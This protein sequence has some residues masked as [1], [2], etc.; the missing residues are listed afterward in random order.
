M[1]NIDFTRVNNVSNKSLDNLFGGLVS[2]F[3]SSSVY[4]YTD[5]NAFLNG[6]I[7]NSPK[8]NK[9]ICLWATKWS[10]FNDPSELKAG[11][12]LFTS[13]MDKLTKDC[14]QK[15]V[16]NNHSI[17]FSLQKDYLPMWYMYGHYGN[18]IMLEF[19][20]QKLFDKYNYR[21]LPCLYKDSTFFDDIISKFINFEYIDNFSALTQEE[22]VYMISLHTSLLISI[23][24]NDYYQYENEV[25]IVGI[26][27]KM[28][29][30]QEDK[31]EFFRVRNGEPIPYVK[32]Y[33]SKDFLKSVWLGPSTQNKVLSKETIQS[34]L[35]SRGFDVDVVC[36]PIPFRS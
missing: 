26:G 9:E 10:H 33:F 36:S 4:Y 22:K 16:D 19:D 20:R 3:N 35:K 31:T 13:N 7:V 8:E 2:S 24:K 32:E 18:G 15:M 34:F 12:E 28:G 23:I 1:I 29:F 5:I 11:L 27:N 17:S 25:R 30:D 6:I 21:F 14:F